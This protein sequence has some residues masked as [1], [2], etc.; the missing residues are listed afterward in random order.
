MV[1]KKSK[2]LPALN[3]S[4]MSDI[5]FLLLTFF[6]LTSSINTDMGIQRRLPPPTDPSVKP[7]DIHK[8]NTFV[9]LV[10]MNDQ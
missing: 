2:K 9:V 7:P 6:L 8:R 1:R 10:N 4:S 5:S 3:S